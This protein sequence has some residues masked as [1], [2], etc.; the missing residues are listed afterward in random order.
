[1][2]PNQ[3]S[4]ASSDITSLFSRFES[5]DPGVSYREVVRDA[6]AIAAVQRWPLLAE[7]QGSPAG[8]DPDRQ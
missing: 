5:M 2:K 3:K 1:M 8:Q 7:L 4:P 6:A